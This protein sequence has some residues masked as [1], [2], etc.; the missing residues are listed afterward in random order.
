VTPVSH[1]PTPPDLPLLTPGD[2]PLP[3]LFAGFIKCSTCQTVVVTHADVLHRDEAG[4]PHLY[5]CR[6]GRCPACDVELALSLVPNSAP[7]RQE[8]L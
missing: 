2:D 5:Q 3:A 6:V 4:C 1:D 7:A 8:R